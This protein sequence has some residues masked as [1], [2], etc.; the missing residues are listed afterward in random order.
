MIIKDNGEGVADEELELITNKFFRGKKNTANKEGSG[1]GL[2]ISSE[3][4]KLM[5]GQLIC[6]NENDGFS[7]ILMLPLE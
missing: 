4:M 5:Q 1:L 3:L 6:R 2:Y 7:V